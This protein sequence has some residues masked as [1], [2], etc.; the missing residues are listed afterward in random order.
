VDWDDPA[1]W[2]AARALATV[3]QLATEG[4]ADVPVYDISADGV[5]GHR[6][7]RLDGC[8]LFVAEGIFAAEVIAP[9]RERQLLADAICLRHHPIVTF[10]RRLVRDLS[11]RRKPPLVLLKRGMRLFRQEPELVARLVA[12]GAYPCGARRAL[13]RIDRLRRTATGAP[14]GSIV[15]VE[16]R[17]PADRPYR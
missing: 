6:E 9:C 2:D 12:M 16:D 10:W 8:P 7:L 14:R 11:E 1:A 3:S 17:R 15:P 4:R 5:V 13:A